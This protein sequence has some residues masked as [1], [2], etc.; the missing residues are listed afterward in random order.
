MPL[1]S[2]N[3]S[4]DISKKTALPPQVLRPT[5]AEISRS[6]LIKNISLIKSKA[7]NAK[8]LAVVKANGYGHGADIVAPVI[9]RYVWGFGVATVEEGI[10]LRKVI[11][12][13]PVLV[14]GA[15]WPFEKNF[16]AALENRL[17]PTVSSFMGLEALEKTARRIYGKMPRETDFFLKIDTGMGRIGLKWDSPEVPRIFEHLKKDAGKILRCEGVYTHFSSADFDAAYT[18]EQY[19]RFSAL[20]R[21]V[22]GNVPSHRRPFFSASNSAGIFFHPGFNMDIVRP[23]ISIYGLQPSADTKVKGLVPALSWK[24]RVVFLKKI[25]RGEPVS[26]GCTYRAPRTP[27]IIATLPVGYADGYRR[28]LSN[29]A[30]VLIRGIRVPVVGRVTMDMIMADVSDLRGRVSVGD[31]VVL[32]GRQGNDIITAEELASRAT[33]GTCGVEGGGT[34]NYEITCGISGE[35]VPR[36]IV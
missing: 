15:L 30:E 26:Y 21:Y 22:V 23:G 17:I 33:E 34:I 13:K 6:A 25:K 8:I 31:E 36:I 35:R 24:T 19:K 7:K 28:S 2:D 14:L 1:S 16:E 4:S 27:T 3:F 20:L 10:A 29:K 18:R 9:E 11:T 12:K 32:I 5:F